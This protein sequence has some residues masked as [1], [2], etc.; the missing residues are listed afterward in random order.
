VNPEAGLYSAALCC[1]KLDPVCPKTYCH[2]IL[3]ANDGRKSRGLRSLAEKR[4]QKNA[5]SPKGS[6]VLFDHD[7]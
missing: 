7:T 4:A 3:T 1:A 5:A 6:D 2:E